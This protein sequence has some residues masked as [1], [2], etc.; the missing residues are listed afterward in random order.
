L[1]LKE[2]EILVRLAH[3]IYFY[4][5]IDKELGVLFPS[6]EKIAKAIAIRDKAKVVPTGVLA[7][8]KLG[9]STLLLSFIFSSNGHQIIIT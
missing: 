7:L 2:K 5:I 3:G 1:R 9:L 6:T 4:P 8:N